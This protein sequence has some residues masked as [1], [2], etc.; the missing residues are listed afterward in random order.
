MKPV[1]DATQT[2]LFHYTVGLNESDLVSYVK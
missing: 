1:H 2:V